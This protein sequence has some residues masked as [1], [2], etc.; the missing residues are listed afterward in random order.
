V[1]LAKM[2]SPRFSDR[3]SIGMVMLL[4]AGAA[5]GLWLVLRQLRSA[6]TAVGNP[7]PWFQGLVFVLGGVSLIGVPVLLFTARRRPWG[8]G[9]IL[10]FSSGTAAWLLWPPVLYHR[11]LGTPQSP[12]AETTSGV[13]FLYGTPLMA[14]YV[15]C[16]LLAGGFFRRAR[17]RRMRRSWQ[18]AF[19]L[20]L[21]LCWAC[22]G[23]YLITRFYI[24]DFSRK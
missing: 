5:I 21:G 22:T 14:V 12:A 3:L 24:D 16:A 8:A 2:K 4:I 19:G 6:E 17:R 20:M 23:L 9:R 11:V 13:C 1:A 18:E 7:E 15:T 10:W